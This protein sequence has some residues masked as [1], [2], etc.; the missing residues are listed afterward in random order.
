MQ[1]TQIAVSTAIPTLTKP[2]A[3]RSLRGLLLARGGPPPSSGMGHLHAVGAWACRQNARRLS[4]QATASVGPAIC[5]VAII[6]SIKRSQYSV[7]MDISWQKLPM[8]AW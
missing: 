3:D 2:S 1:P 4:K 5:S 6:H 8:V 7:L